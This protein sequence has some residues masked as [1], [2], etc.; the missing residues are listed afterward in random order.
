[1]AAKHAVR[2]SMAA[3]ACSDCSVC[4]MVRRREEGEGVAPLV[5]SKDPHLNL[6]LP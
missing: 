4:S 2:E 6:W 3:C 5:Q 1:M